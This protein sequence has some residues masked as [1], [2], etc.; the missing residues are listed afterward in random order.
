MLFHLPELRRVQRLLVVDNNSSAA[1]VQIYSAI[2]T[3]PFSGQVTC[4]SSFFSPF[5][6]D[7]LL[8]NE[9]V[10]VVVFPSNLYSIS[11]LSSPAWMDGPTVVKL[12][13][14]LCDRSISV[15]EPFE[16]FPCL[17]DAKMFSGNIAPLPPRLPHTE[18]L[19]RGE[20]KRRKRGEGSK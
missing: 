4:S 7:P 11:L 10:F 19:R 5:F 16:C 20:R 13:S 3:L 12:L 9:R 8:L 15:V 14:G 17:E 18:F 2:K 1:A 6:L